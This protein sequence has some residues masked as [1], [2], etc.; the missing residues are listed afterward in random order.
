MKF[1]ISLFFTA[2]LLAQR[3]V[4]TRSVTFTG[5]GLND[6][7]SGGTYTGGGAV[8]VYCVVI[9]RAAIPDAINWGTAGSCRSGGTGIAITGQPQALSNGVNV[10]FAA[11]TGHTPTDR[12][13]SQPTTFLIGPAAD[14][15]RKSPSTIVQTDVNGEVSI[16]T[17]VLLPGGAD[18]ID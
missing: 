18:Q 7:V 14:Y 8:P 17:T 11:T 16:G 15:S 10:A 2:S 6:M 1:S 3:A 9:A 4:P 13:I 12:W 5:I